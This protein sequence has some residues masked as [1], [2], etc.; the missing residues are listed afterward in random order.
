MPL[1]QHKRLDLIFPWRYP[2]AL[3]AP[4]AQLDRASDYESEGR[5]FESLWARHKINDLAAF[6]A[7][8]GT[9]KTA[10]V[11]VGSQVMICSKPFRNVSTRFSAP[12]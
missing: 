8:L 12:N 4:I 6:T 10:G 9:P 11:P 1:P 7:I 3:S 2:H 5:A